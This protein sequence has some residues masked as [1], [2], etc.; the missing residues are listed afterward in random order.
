MGEQVLA[1]LLESLPTKNLRTGALVFD[2]QAKGDHCLVSYLDYRSDHVHVLRAK[3]VVMACPK[4]VVKKTLADLEP[5]RLTAMGKLSYRAYVVGNLLIN[6]PIK[7]DF[8]DLFMLGKAGE[9]FGD[10]FGAYSRQRITDVVLGAYAKVDSQRSVLSLY[11]GLPFEGGRSILYSPEAYAAQRQ[12]FLQ[13][14]AA[15]ILPLFG[16]SMADVAELRLARWGHPM[17]VPAVGLIADGVT[18]Q[19]RKPFK[20]R[21]F[22]VEQD[23]W[24]L[25]A[26]ETCAQEAMHFAPQ[27]DQLLKS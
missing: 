18:A 4:F 24:M 1:K 19:L 20:N 22:F 13:H 17:P 12:E 6:Q 2:V 25:A 9:D 16:L 15:E 5:E 3:A 26:I 21:V 27:V 11:R 14:C 8:Y 10:I 23:N 7:D